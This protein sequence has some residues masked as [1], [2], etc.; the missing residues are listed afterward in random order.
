M[1]EVA[2]LKMM[3]QKVKARRI[4][5]IG[6]FDGTSAIAMAE[7]LPADGELITCEINAGVAGVA[8]RRARRHP[9]GHKIDVRI[10]PALETLQQLTGLFDLI[11]IDA[12]TRNYVHYYH[13]AKALLSP[14]GVLLIDNMRASAMVLTVPV[15]D[16]SAAAI[17]E[18]TGEVASDANLDA[19]LMNVRDGVMVITRRE[20]TGSSEGQKR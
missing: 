6:T 15:A 20:K 4:L 11:F 13:H 8:R 17:Q 9:D 16:A 12:D 19:V 5:E 7:C 14:T 3:V 2:F 10:G 1:K 18:V